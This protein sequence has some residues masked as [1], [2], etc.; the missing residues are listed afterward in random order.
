MDAIT[1]YQP[2]ATAIALGFKTFETR[3]WQPRYKP[4]LI[5]IHAGRH[6][7]NAT[8][9]WTQLTAAKF[10]LELPEMLPLGAILCVCEFVGAYRAETVYPHIGEIERRFGNYADGRFAWKLKVK[11]VFNPPLF[12]QGKQG[13]WKCDLLHLPAGEPSYAKV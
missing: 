7:D 8:R 3:S 6:W 2:W 5:A 9:D 4:G 11:E 13:L 1:L 12:A 10:G